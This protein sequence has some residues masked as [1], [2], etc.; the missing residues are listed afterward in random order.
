MDLVSDESV[1]REVLEWIAS[2]EKVN[3]GHKLPP[4]AVETVRRPWGY[5]KVDV[6]VAEEE[7]EVSVF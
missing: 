4:K 5:A 6:A 7:P 1:N 3:R 2:V